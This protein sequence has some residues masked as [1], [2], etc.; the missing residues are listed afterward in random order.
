MTITEKQYQKMLEEDVEKRKRNV[1]EEL[2][3]FL[4]YFYYHFVFFAWFAA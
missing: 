3:N 2:D 4:R 1:T